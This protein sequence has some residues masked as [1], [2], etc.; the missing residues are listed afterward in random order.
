[1]HLLYDAI[2]A[3]RLPDL[4]R[5]LD[6]ATD[7]VIQACPARARIR[8]TVATDLYAAMPVHLPLPTRTLSTGAKRLREKLLR[9]EELARPAELDDLDMESAY[10]CPLLQWQ[11][12]MRAAQV[13][14]R[15]KHKAVE[16]LDIDLCPPPTAIPSQRPYQGLLAYVRDALGRWR[17]PSLRDG[18]SA[19]NAPA[20]IALIAH[21]VVA[22]Q[23]VCACSVQLQ[24]PFTLE[25]TPPPVKWETLQVAKP[26]FIG[27]GLARLLG[28]FARG[29]LTTSRGHEVQEVMVLASARE[30]ALVRTLAALLLLYKDARTPLARGRHY[31]LAAAGTL[32]DVGLLYNEALARMGG[33]P[34]AL[35]RF[36][37]AA[38]LTARQGQVLLKALTEAH[39]GQEEEEEVDFLAGPVA[40]ASAVRWYLGAY[41]TTT[42]PEGLAQRSERVNP[43]SLFKTWELRKLGELP[44]FRDVGA[45]VA[46]VQHNLFA[47]ATV[48]RDLEKRHH[49][50]QQL[51]AGTELLVLLDHGG[52]RRFYFD[53][54]RAFSVTCHGPVL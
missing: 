24:L 29:A 11:W 7:H 3:G 16:G 1:V 42:E 31:L 37:V 35:G 52:D 32:V 54:H 36:L 17:V 47:S 2:P 25:G 13:L 27:E 26:Q 12:L 21:H 45:L 14:R 43:V 30:D 18:E 44:R 4:Q 33:S 15:P 10:A 20:H 49:G 23:L 51:L 19:P 53:L 39:R 8:V 6:A 41:V 38:V 50:Q 22:Q 34:A 46:V 5:E 48:R 9:A 28:T 40:D